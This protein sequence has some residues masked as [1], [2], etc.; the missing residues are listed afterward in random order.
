MEEQAMRAKDIM[1]EKVV[2]IGINESVFDAAEMLL[3]ANVSAAPVV[4][5][6]GTVVGIVSE[7]DLIRR[8]EIDTTAKKSYASWSSSWSGTR[9]SAFPSCARA[10]WSES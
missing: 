8:N 4:T 9:S 5:A 1:S 6:K 2:S 3:G 10:A 7:A